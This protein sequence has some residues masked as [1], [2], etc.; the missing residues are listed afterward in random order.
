MIC[1]LCFVG[2][3]LAKPISL[4][5]I[6]FWERQ[7]V[8]Q[9]RPLLQRRPRPYAVVFAKVAGGNDDG[10]DDDSDSASRGS[11]GDDGQPSSGNRV[12][13]VRSGRVNDLLE[14]LDKI[15]LEQDPDEDVKRKQAERYLDRET[16]LIWLST[17]LFGEIVKACSDYLDKPIRKMVAASLAILFGFFSATSASTIIGSVADWDP[18]AAAVL[19]V[20]TE[21]F[22]RIYYSKENKT[23]LLR[24][25][26]AFKIGL[27]YGMAV[28]AF[29]L[30]T[31]CAS[32]LMQLNPFVSFAYAY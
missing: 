4:P 23:L 2:S 19:L 9:G 28:D 29:K 1:P 16:Q 26:N 24:L 22:T 11:G 30:S 5:V 14:R 8:S 31:V 21:A 6:S 7:L 12:F 20:W 25:A 17:K 15:E 18:L 13:D 10:N 3:P 32:R 27:I